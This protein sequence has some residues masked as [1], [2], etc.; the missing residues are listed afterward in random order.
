MAKRAVLKEVADE[1]G[2][3]HIY[4]RQVACGMRRNP[5]AMSLI[6]KKRTEV[7]NDMQGLCATVQAEAKKDPFARTL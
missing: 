3:S 4:V 1:M 7:L 2:L 5:E 6:V